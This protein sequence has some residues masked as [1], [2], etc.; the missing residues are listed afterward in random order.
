MW[1]VQ[2]REPGGPEQMMLVDVPMPQP[3]PGDALVRLEASGVN[4]LDV[5][6][7]TGLYKAA[8]PLTLGNEGAGTIEAIGPGNG[9]TGLGVG[10]R[11]AYAMVGGSYAEYAAVPAAR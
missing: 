7:R 6:Y 4:F 9:V 5:Y 11:V 2:I 8:M 10:D 3:G 1:C